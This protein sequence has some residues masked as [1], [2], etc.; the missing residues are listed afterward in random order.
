MTRGLQVSFTK[1]VREAI[2]READARGLRPQVLV[3]AVMRGVL[4][5]N[6]LDAVIDGDDPRRLAGGHARD[7]ITGLTMLQGGLLYLIG[8]HAGRDGTCRLSSSGFHARLPGHSYGGVQQALSA[9][10][11][12]GL[13]R[14]VGAGGRWTPQAHALTEA[15][16]LVY[17]QLADA[18]AE[19]GGA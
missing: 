11:A 12:K 13:I 17:R 16:S 9:L 7:L 19:G 3:A 4:A 14:R 10:R 8:Q 15:G 2:R 1:D 5:G 6:L 18:E